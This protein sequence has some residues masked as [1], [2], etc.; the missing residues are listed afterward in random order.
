MKLERTKICVI[1]TGYVGLV[2][3]TC[4]AEIGHQV[5]CVDNNKEKIKKLQN[6]IMPIYEPG[7]DKLVIKNKQAGRLSFFTKIR[8]GVENSDVIFVAVHT[9]T[10][11]SGETNLSYVESVS[12]EIAKA[13]N[14]Y[15]VIV[16]KSTM[17]V[18]TGKKIKEIIK[19]YS[20]KDVDFDVV[21]NPEFLREGT[22]VKDFLYPER[23]V[24]GLENK[25][26]EKIMRQMYYP[27]KAPIIVTNIETAEMI[28]HASNAF[29]ATKI[30]FINAVANICE[31][32]GADVEE[33]AQ[34][35]GLD[36]RIGKSFLKAGIGFGGSCLPK[37]I[38]A[39][40]HISTKNGYNFKL[41]KRIRQINQLQK[42]NF[43][44]KVKDKLQNLKGKNLAILGLAFKPNTDD[45]RNA[46]SVDII[47]MFIKQGAIIKAYDPIA[48]ESAKQ[49]FKDKIT[50]CSDIYE[51]VQNA[52]ALII[53]T[54]WDEFKHMDLEKIKKLLKSSKIIDGR[55]IFDP[56]KMRKL[57]FNYSCIGRN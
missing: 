13:M 38:D 1:G 21:S 43:V 44:K 51:T 15:K 22:A 46:P 3:G 41:L 20:S 24:I 35:M 34:V 6:N 32:V 17:P 30:S 25:K 4:L 56:Q 10:Q 50:Y 53:L 31:R 27:I 45:M 11:K 29:L 47:N 39:F 8:Q 19:A 18:E 12:Q 9:P 2:V 52:D 14:S 28:K 37:D 54:E 49:I 57:G 16:S 5:I 7:L 42:E 23:I 40:I 33:I 55:N 26:A 36:Q 48:K